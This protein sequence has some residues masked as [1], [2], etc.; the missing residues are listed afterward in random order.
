M[1]S[2]YNVQ[3]NKNLPGSAKIKVPLPQI[4]EIAPV[5]APFLVVIIEHIQAAVDLVDLMQDPCL[6]D[7]RKYR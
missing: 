6:P 3:F 4:N 2:V 1:I 5:L 7:L